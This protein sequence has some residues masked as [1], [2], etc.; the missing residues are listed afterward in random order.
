M[1]KQY[2]N[3]GAQIINLK[4]NKHIDGETIVLECFSEKT[5]LDLITP[6]SDLISIGRDKYGKHVYSENINFDE[7]IEFNKIDYAICCRLQTIIGCFEKMV[8]NFLMHKYCEKMKGSGDKQVKDYSWIERYNNGQSC[9]DLLKIDETFA[10][11]TM[12]QANLDMISRRKGV[13]T[14]IKELEKSNNNENYIVSHYQ[15][16]YGYIPMF[17][18]IHSL[19]LGQLLT[20]FMMLKQDD[21]NELL[22]LFNSTKNKRYSDLQIEKF[23]KDIGRIYV[24]RN[25]VNHYEPIFPFIQNTENRTFSSLTN[26]FEK[27]TSYYKRTNSYFI[28][29][30]DVT[31]NY[32][33]RNSYSLTFHLKIEKVLE[34]LK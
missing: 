25:I 23:E 28:E 34:A 12:Q 29:P 4:T 30:F 2:Q 20:L 21:K 13:L 3:I 6:Y 26:I 7:Y 19:S 16:K 33:S 27:L 22:C 17:V 5:Y 18:A 11:G 24:I 9:F 1:K 14:K 31:K 15:R 8:K 32:K 10:E